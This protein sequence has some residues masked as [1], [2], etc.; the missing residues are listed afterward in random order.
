MSDVFGITKEGMEILEHNGVLVPTWDGKPCKNPKKYLREQNISL[1]E[2]NQRIQR[3]KF[4]D[5]GK[6]SD[7]R[8]NYCVQI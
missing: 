6:G 8:N 1:D 7:F 2:Y 5:W 3:G 4:F